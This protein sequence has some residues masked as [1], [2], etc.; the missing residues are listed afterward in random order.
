MRD[1]MT[2]PAAELAAALDHLIA[3]RKRPDADDPRHGRR[4]D[5]TEAGYRARDARLAVERTLGPAAVAAA[6]AAAELRDARKV[7]AAALAAKAIG[8]RFEPVQLSFMEDAVAEAKA[9][10]ETTEAAA[11][12][13]AEALAAREA[14]EAEHA[15]RLAET[16]AGLAEAVRDVAAAAAEAEA[17][18]E[19]LERAEAVY[20]ARLTAAQEWLRTTGFDE[21]S[22]PDGSLYPSAD[23]SPTRIGG[24]DWPSIALVS[25]PGLIDGV[26]RLAGAAEPLVQREGAA[27]AAP[28]TA[29]LCDH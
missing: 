22:R 28:A 24:A 1:I 29:L 26:Q 21:I 27:R 18:L 4:S 10:A 16:H 3:V 2:S 25:V 12:A 14:L 19:V 20:A 6:E 11:R 23:G 8:V 9:R 17:A 5:L 13:E 15:P 7:L